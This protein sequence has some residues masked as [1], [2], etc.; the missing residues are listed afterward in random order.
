[1]EVLALYQ[2]KDVA[3]MKGG[4]EELRLGLLE[5]CEAQGVLGTLL[6]AD[7]GVNGTVAGPSS[8]L[9]VL[10]EW[11]VARG[12]DALEQKRASAEEN[13]FLRMKVAHK[14][15][16]VTFGVDGIEPENEKGFYVEP[17]EWNELIADPETLVIDTR[18]DYEVRIGTFRNAV[19][20]NTTTFRNF[21]EFVEKA[22]VGK[23]DKS[24]KIAMFCTGGI[25]CEKST[26][27][28]R[29]KGFKNVFHLH[30]G[31]LKYLENVTEEESMWE[32][33]CFVFDRRVSVKH[34]LDQGTHDLCVGCRGPV[35]EEEKL[36][37]NYKEG[38]HCPH[39]V[40]KYNA[41]GKH[42]ERVRARRKHYVDNNVEKVEDFLG[43]NSKFVRGVEG[44][45]EQAKAAA[46]VEE[47]QS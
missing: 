30:G 33:E 12:F 36:S 18:N 34:G 16:I 13:P 2:F 9:D 23:T 8:G 25:R 21:P 19:N 3:Q 17:E 4:A 35:S 43:P 15:E 1:M 44:K 27:F 26:A 39:C 20:P 42:M 41:E 47:A 38:A 14:K 31:I 46:S 40:E 10:V 7:E 5:V 45:K 32:G 22:L 28:L 11:L 24:K 37:P 6:V 29:R